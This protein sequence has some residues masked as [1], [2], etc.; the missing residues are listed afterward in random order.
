VGKLPGFL[1]RLFGSA[2]PASSPTTELGRRGEAA[3]ARLLKDKGYKVLERNFRVRQGEIDLVVFRDGVLV[4]VEVR[5]QTEPAMI[6]PLRTITR[7]KQRRVIK[8]A[9]TYL[10]VK[11][12]P[13]TDVAPRFDVVS[14][15]F[16]RAGRPAETKHVEGA[17]QVSSKGF[18]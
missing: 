16:D 9:Q 14:V 11:K 10:T 15:L 13:A 7:G 3:A 8:A 17:F 2:C 4:F 18:S 1:S 12:F 6:D 5:A